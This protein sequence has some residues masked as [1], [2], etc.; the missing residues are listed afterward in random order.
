MGYLRIHCKH[1]LPTQAWNGLFFMYDK[2]DR[3]GITNTGVER[4]PCFG[5]GATARA[6]L[7]TGRQFYGFE[8]NKEFYRRAVE[9]MIVLPDDGQLTIEDVM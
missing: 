9:E 7:E 8:I 4:S 6:C 5:S 2:T 1:V 3:Q